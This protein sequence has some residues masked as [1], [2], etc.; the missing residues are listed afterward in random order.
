MQRS[1]VPSWLASQG[2]PRMKSFV[3]LAAFYKPRKYLSKF[4]LKCKDTDGIILG[5]KKIYRSQIKRT[6]DY[7]VNVLMLP[8]YGNESRNENDTIFSKRIL[9]PRAAILLASASDRELWFQS[10]RSEA[11]AKRIAALG[12]RMLETLSNFHI[13]SVYRPLKPS[14]ILSL[15]RMIASFLNRG[16]L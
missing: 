1:G 16:Q 12:T 8:I 9:V 15:P 4:Q 3:I 14:P 5:R 2:L 11:L 6:H 10:S 13:H 7:S